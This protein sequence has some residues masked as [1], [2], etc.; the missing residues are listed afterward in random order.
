M[1][2][3]YCNGIISVI[4]SSSLIKN[5]LKNDDNLLILEEEITKIIPNIPSSHTKEYTDIIEM[6]SRNSIWK[7]VIKIKV[8]KL[9][10]SFD[11]LPFPFNKLPIKNIR[12]ILD[13]RKTIKNL[14]NISKNLSVINKLVVSDNSLLWRHLYRKNV[15]LS[16]VEHG[17]ASYRI[18]ETKKNWKYFIKLLYSKFSSIDPN[19]KAN[20]I[21]ISD[22]KMSLKSKNFAKKNI[23]ITPISLNL[24]QDIKEVFNDFLKIYKKEKSEEFKELQFIKKKYHNIFIYM[25]S[26][27]VPNNEYSE[28]LKNQISQIDNKNDAVFLI[29]PHGNDMKREYSDYF[30]DLNLLS[31]NF[32]KKM[33]KY[34]PIEVLLFFFNNATAFG[35]YS[36]T[37]LY[38]NWWLNKKSIFTEVKNSSIQNILVSEYSSVYED[39]KNL[40]KWSIK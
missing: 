2:V 1:N 28:Y 37:H 13:K 40:N 6:I 10:I 14:L 31:I 26:N 39:F 33:N 19:L 30:K 4:V 29:K 8:K 23:G 17:A 32:E 27:F 36:S 16:Y 24:Q 18:G 5:K 35:S 20:S 15:D 12:L 7:K 34:I 11:S 38:S 9:F 21:Y 22:N 3:F 25:P